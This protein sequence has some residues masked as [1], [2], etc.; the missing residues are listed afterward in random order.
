[1]RSLR[2]CM[3]PW[4]RPS[5]A[6]YCLLSSVFS[7]T[8]VEAMVGWTGQGS[9]GLGRVVLIA[10]LAARVGVKEAVLVR[11]RSK[12]D[13]QRCELLSSLGRA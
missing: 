3:V 7:S 11:K 13:G 10:E 8:A 9:V 6:S 12:L 4:A 2:A 5:G 1:M